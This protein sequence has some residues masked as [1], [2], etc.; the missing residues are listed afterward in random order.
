M[1]SPGGT[2]TDTTGTTDMELVP[3]GDEASTAAKRPRADEEGG[4]AAAAG[5]DGE[6]GGSCNGA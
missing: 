1:L 5:A 6:G 3:E 2:T 4:G